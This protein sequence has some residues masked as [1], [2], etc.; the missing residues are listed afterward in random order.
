[1]AATWSGTS[2]SALM[3]AGSWPSATTRWI[4]IWNTR[5]GAEERRVRGEGKQ[6][7]A[8]AFSSDGRRFAAGGYDGVTRV[9]SMAGGSSVAALRGQRSRIYDIGFG[10]TS[11]R[12]VSAGDDGSVRLW[13]VGPTQVVE[14][15]G[16]RRRHRVQPRR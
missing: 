16:R 13:D 9:W 7:L 6:L 15:A 2:P 8:A 5:S 4:R 3:G 14:P 11:D 12:L 10:R 1:M